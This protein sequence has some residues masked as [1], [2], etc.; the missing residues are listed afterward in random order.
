MNFLRFITT[1]AFLGSLLHLGTNVYAQQKNISGRVTDATTGLPLPGAVILRAGSLTGTVTNSSGEFKIST[2]V[3]QKLIFTESGYRIKEVEVKKRNKYHIRLIPVEDPVSEPFEIGYSAATLKSSTGSVQTVFAKHFN[4]G[5]NSNI[6]QLINGKFAGLQISSPG[7]APNENSLLSLRGTSLLGTESNPLLIVDGLPLHNHGVSGIR[8]PFT[9]LN[10]SDIESFT[11]L[12]DAA[13]TSIYGSRGGNG[14]VL[15][16][17]KIAKKGQPLRINYHGMVSVGKVTDKYEVFTAN[18][19]RNLVFDKY[20][21]YLN[22]T[23]LLGNS[24]TNWQDRIYQTAISTDHILS[25]AG[26]QG[27]VPYRVS[28]GFTDEKGVLKTDKFSR[29]TMSLGVTPTLMNDRLKMRMNLKLMLNNNRFAPREAIKSAAQFDPTQPVSNDSQFGGYFTWTSA[30]GFPIPGAPV[31]PFAQIEM[32]GDY[33]RIVGSIGNI[34]LEYQLQKIP[35]LRLKMNLGYDV[36]RGAGL[37]MLPEN[38]PTVYEPVNGGG[39]LREYDQN[40]NGNLVDLYAQYNK[41]IGKSNINA[42]AGISRH[43]FHTFGKDHEYNTLE[44]IHRDQAVMDSSHSIVS[45]FAK[46][47]YSLNRKYLLAASIRED[48]NSYYSS[49]NRWDAFPSLAAAWLLSEESLFKNINSLN[50]LKIRYSIGISGYQS[51]GSHFMPQI[52]GWMPGAYDQR[53]LTGDRWHWRSLPFRADPDLRMEYTTAQNIGLD[54]SIADSRIFGSLEAYERIT[55]DFVTFVQIGNA[56][57]PENLMLANAGSI[58]NKGL[59][60]VVNLIPVK[61]SSFTW[62]I[63]FNAAYNENKVRSFRNLPVIGYTNALLTGTLSGETVNYSQIIAP[64]FPVRSFFLN[65][66]YYSTQNKPIE[67]TY[68]E[69]PDRH[70]I[71]GDNRM[72]SGKAAPDYIFGLTSQ[73]KWNNLD[74]YISGRSH[75]GSYVYN[76]IWAD[77]GNLKNLYNQAGFLNNPDKHVIKTTFQ[78]PNYTSDIYLSDGSFIKIDNISAGYSVYRLFGR[79]TKAR[80][81]VVMQNVATFSRYKGIDPEVINGIDYYR[82]PHPGNM[83]YGISIDF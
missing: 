43:K 32:T 58:Q 39:T 35:A 29:V 44:T 14:V 10:P 54:F 25:V 66:Q 83:V 15:I 60:A 6:Q 26:N 16:N 71:A 23:N 75:L 48:R 42:V 70:I 63:G 65:Q 78:N 76:N 62:E 51:T 5:S 50:L 77:A 73:I 55:R 9:I 67:G 52:M 11:L 49:G 69:R 72:V 64:G 46:I 68:V 41:D 3:G 24:E 13:A 36:S 19:F 34:Q 57:F 82:Y 20:P 59:E 74:L 56:P 80:F 53:M 38:Y 18:E 17:S 28:Y 22:A 2:A 81:Y 21:T 12:K 8:N 37:I 7:G 1:V 61:T 33:S 30:N 45:V 47:E 4:R 40:R 31:N 79:K 27:G